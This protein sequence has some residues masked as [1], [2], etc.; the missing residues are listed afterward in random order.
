MYHVQMT[1]QEGTKSKECIDKE[2][3]KRLVEPVQGFLMDH[4]CRNGFCAYLFNRQRPSLRLK[5]TSR[6]LHQNPKNYCS[7]KLEIID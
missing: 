6:I 2:L 5:R 3:G 7:R 4:S 1:M